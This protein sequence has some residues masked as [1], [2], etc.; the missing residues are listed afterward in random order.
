MASHRLDIT[1][2]PEHWNYGEALLSHDPKREEDALLRLLARVQE[3]GNDE[4]KQYVHSELFR[5]YCSRGAR[6]PTLRV[7]T[8]LEELQGC[9]P[10][11]AKRVLDDLGDVEAASSVVNRYLA[12]LNWDRRLTARCERAYSLK[13]LKL[14]VLV[15]RQAEPEPIYELFLDLAH[16]GPDLWL[17]WNEPLFEALRVL[18]SRDAL[19]PPAA[20]VLTALM[21]CRALEALAADHG[22][23]PIQELDQLSTRLQERF[24][25][26]DS[27][28]RCQSKADPEFPDVARF[29]EY[30]E[31]ETAL[32]ALDTAAQES[33]VVRLLA[34]ARAEG[35][36]WDVHSAQIKLFCHH[37]RN[38]QQREALHTLEQ[39]E[40]ALTVDDLG[41][42]VWL[43]AN[44]VDDL[45]AVQEASECI[46]R[47]LERLKW[48]RSLF[49]HCAEV[50]TLK[51]LQ[52]R[53]QVLQEQPPEAVGETLRDLA[54]LSE[55]RRFRWDSGLPEALRTLEQRQQLPCTAIPILNALVAG[56]ALKALPP[57][58]GDAVLHHLTAMRRR[59]GR[60]AHAPT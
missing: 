46:D 3:E 42:G 16:L 14:R 60:T 55:H 18:D 25:E 31:W 48:D 54:H 23:A 10:W 44:L 27:L 41:L 37:C 5:H 58:H 51:Q 22:D 7:L 1:R 29:P 2:F 15:L 17:Q 19:P 38:G 4:D 26:D 20:V 39:L 13:L 56:R 43:I 6:E 57:D 33:A 12:D 53:I 40:E 59:S 47:Q 49:A 11:L 52:L 34:R 24:A 9:S 35:T 8:Q 21:R 30:A 50:T 32:F 36:P 45:G 28:S